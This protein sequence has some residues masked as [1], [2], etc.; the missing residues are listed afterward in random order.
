MFYDV[1]VWLCKRDG[2]TPTAVCR[3]IGLSNAVAPYWKKSGKAPKL[4][5]LQKIAERFGVSVN[6]LLEKA[7]SEAPEE[8]QTLTDYENELIDL[9]RQ[10]S[11]EQQMQEIGRLRL[12]AEQ[13]S[14][15]KAATA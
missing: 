15:G 6:Y 7:D 1:L 8:S 13:S 2:T 14:K 10:L 4:E 9:F 3:D 11:Y 12:L 5:T